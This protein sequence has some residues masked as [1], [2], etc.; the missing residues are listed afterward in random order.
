MPRRSNATQTI[1]PGAAEVLSNPSNDAI[2]LIAMQE[3]YT[4][5][6]TIEGVSP[7][8]FH[9]YS[10]EQNRIKEGSGKNSPLRKTD[11]LESMIWRNEKK[12]ICLPGQ[13]VHRAIVDA[14]RFRQ[15]PRSPR[16]SAMDLYKAA[17]SPLTELATLG[18]A[19]WDF[20]DERRHTVNRS[21]ITRQRPAFN[22]GWK[23]NFVFQVNLP[24]YVAGHDV[25]DLLSL[26]GRAVGVADSRPTYG[27]FVVTNFEVRD[28]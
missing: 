13:Y 12:Q 23:A 14:A 4:V 22:A 9:R 5:N 27:R 17:I 6:F 28:S 25:L 16:K 10:V 21:A 26:A 3:P 8:I 15:D 24:E 7:I 20:V 18:K 11:D 1:E 2:R 19:R